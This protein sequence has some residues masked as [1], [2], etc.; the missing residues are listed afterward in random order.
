M[1][2]KENNFES[3]PIQISTSNDMLNLF[4]LHG[5]LRGLTAAQAITNLALK[6]LETVAFNLDEEN[7]KPLEEMSPVE[8]Q[9]ASSF[10]EKI[11]KEMKNS[12]NESKGP[13]QIS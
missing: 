3:I 7:S 1:A 6:Q 12:K 5:A 4:E 8:V 9:K 13:Q 2:R 11:L 10:A